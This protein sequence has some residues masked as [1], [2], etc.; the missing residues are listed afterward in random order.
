M[1]SE[2][3]WEIEDVALYLGIPK[4]SVY[5]MTAR[6]GRER[7]PYVKLG[8]RL[9]FRKADIDHWLDLL[10]VVPSAGLERAKKKALGR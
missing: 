5:K 3:L 1:N 6:G 4:S 7:I 9:R 2:R 10:A 8:G